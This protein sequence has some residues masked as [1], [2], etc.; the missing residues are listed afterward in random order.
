[1]Y[2]VWKSLKLTLLGRDRP[3]GQVQKEKTEERGMKALCIITSGVIYLQWGW[4]PGQIYPFHSNFLFPLTMNMQ[5]IV[6]RS[7]CWTWDLESQVNILSFAQEAPMGHE[8]QSCRGELRGW[9]RPP[10]MSLWQWVPK[11]MLLSNT[12]ILLHTRCCFQ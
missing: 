8:E 1:M 12:E 11:I 7:W 2:L 5:A 9:S 10:R 3:L 6:P 4:K